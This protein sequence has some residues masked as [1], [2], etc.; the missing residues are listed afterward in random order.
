MMKYNETKLNMCSV[1][2]YFLTLDYHT[3]CSTA[4]SYF[5]WPQERFS[6]SKCTISNEYF[7]KPSG[8]PLIPGATSSNVVA[9]F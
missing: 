2:G 3:W 5:M 4:P 8:T 9:I 6:E 1:L 7:L